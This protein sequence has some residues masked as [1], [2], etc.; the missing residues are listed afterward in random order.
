MDQKKLF[1][2]TESLLQSLRIKPANL[3]WHYTDTQGL[4]GIVLNR[5]IRLSHPSFLND[6]SELRYANSIYDEMLEEIRTNSQDPL[7]QE[8]VEGYRTYKDD[9][10]N[11]YQE[12][13][14]SFV[15]FVA[16][17][18]GDQDRLDL[19]RQYGDDGQGFALGFRM[20]Q[21]RD[22]VE[23]HVEKMKIPGWI[24]ILRVLYIEDEQRDYT[25]R[26]L[27][28]WIDEF[29]KDRENLRNKENE[30]VDVY[31]VEVYSPLRT[32]L[33]AIAPFFKHPCYENENENR[34]ALNSSYIDPGKMA[35]L[36]RRGYFKPYIDF[37][38][39]DDKNG[40]KDDGNDA[41][42]LDTVMIG[43]TTPPLWSERSLRMFLAN[44]RLKSVKTE[45]S[46]LPYLNNKKW[47]L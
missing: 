40:I 27:N 8:F 14:Y 34:I 44:Q 35:F 12:D 43:P 15:V 2:D 26:I 38:I 32:A 46:D 13:E 29:K 6:P 3:L 37:N 5:T 11:Q 39:E 25:R 22:V 9:Y 1:E 23:R 16:S 41:F 42:P 28:F 7:V 31:M 30:P 45:H 18:C 36:A 21:L 10:Q 33:G 20:E 19:W 24:H 4:K 47:S 17:F